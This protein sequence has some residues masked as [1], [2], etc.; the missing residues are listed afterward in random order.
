MYGEEEEKLHGEVF[1]ATQGTTTS[2]LD[3]G[4]EMSLVEAALIGGGG[5]RQR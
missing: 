4:E 1:V 3:K 2:S 5:S